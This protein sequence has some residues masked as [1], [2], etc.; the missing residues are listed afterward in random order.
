MWLKYFVWNL[1]RSKVKEAT[2]ERV[3]GLKRL[4]EPHSKRLG[5]GKHDGTGTAWWGKSSRVGQGQ[6]G[7]TWI[8]SQNSEGRT[9][10]ILGQLGLCC[11]RP[12]KVT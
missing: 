3:M 10:Q 11:S 12:T 4:S 1:R 9:M 2:P 5:Q 6:H 8:C 7:W